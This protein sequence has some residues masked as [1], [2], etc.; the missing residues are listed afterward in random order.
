MCPINLTRGLLHAYVIHSLFERVGSSQVDLA[1]S[2]APTS[3]EPPL[4]GLE[5]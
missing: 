2:R 3:I 1:S 4:F 5:D